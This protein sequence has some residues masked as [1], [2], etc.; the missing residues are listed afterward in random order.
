MKMEKEGELKVQ[1]LINL[2][3]SENE[4]RVYIATL[5]IGR[6][7]VSKI[8]R[9]AGVSRTNGYNILDALVEKGLARISGKEPKEEYAAESPEKIFTYFEKKH[10]ELVATLANARELIPELTTMEKRKDRPQV[11]FYEGTEGLKQV[12]EDTLTSTETIRAF[13]TVEE[14]HEGLKDY[15]P[16]YYKR[17]SGKGIFIRTI[18]PD[19]P[20]S[21]ERT[22]HDKEEARESRLVPHDEF[23][24]HP[25]IN[26]Y[27][28]KVMVASWREKLGIIIE[29][30]EIADAM[31]KIFELAWIGTHALEK[32]PALGTASENTV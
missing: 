15:F 19:T 21:V 13:A 6:G 3:L 10:T 4:S 11:K 25:E 17:R 23:L 1:K 30:D 20:V 9:K 12:Y 31:K 24:F 32:D 18:L 14:M 28:N 8:C 2:G 16:H 26:I 22:K 7:T 29:S 27:D 5:E